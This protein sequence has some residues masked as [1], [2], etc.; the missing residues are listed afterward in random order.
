LHLTRKERG[1]LGGVK[2]KE[3]DA[4]GGYVPRS[5][6]TVS[7]CPLMGKSKGVANPLLARSREKQF[8]GAGPRKERKG[9]HRKR[10]RQAESQSDCPMDRPK[11]TPGLQHGP[12][13]G[14][15]KREQKNR[16]SPPWSEKK[17]RGRARLSVGKMFHLEGTA[18]K[19]K[20]RVGRERE[21]WR[22]NKKKKYVGG[23][24]KGG[25]VGVQIGEKI[26]TGHRGGELN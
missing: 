2:G 9:W 3:G 14:K 20:T 19:K 6:K 8:F 25:G 16:R 5:E 13:E 22:T 1:R 11:A 18:E 4:Q 12:Q 26:S 23:P 10:L 21:T 24:F 7:R 17:K 15:G